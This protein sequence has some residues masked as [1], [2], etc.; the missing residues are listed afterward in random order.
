MGYSH[1]PTRKLANFRTRKYFYNF[2][3]PL[4]KDIS[5]EFFHY[6]NNLTT[7][8]F[9][10]TKTHISMVNYS[11]KLHTTIYRKLSLRTHQDFNGSLGNLGGDGEGLEEGGLL[12]SEAG[13]LAGQ[14]H[15]KGSDDSCLGR[16]RHLLHE[17]LVPHLRQLALGEHQPHV[18][19]DVRQQPLQG[20]VGLQVPT[21]RLAHHR[22][23]SHQHNCKRKMT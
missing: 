15:V 16:S 5:I 20:R 8:T 2:Q 10:I 14:D 19:L 17:D 9:N 21:D 6:S 12:G 11:I 1:F 3:M 18:A 22:V 23:L 7:P 4:F 13:V